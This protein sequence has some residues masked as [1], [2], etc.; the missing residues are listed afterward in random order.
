VQY[1]CTGGGG[2]NLEVTY[3]IFNQDTMLGNTTITWWNQTSTQYQKVTYESRPWNSSKYLTHTGFSENY[4]HWAPEDTGKYYYHLPSAELYNDAG[5][6]LGFEYA[7]ECY[8]YIQVE[9]NA[10]LCTISVHY[11]NGVLL[12]GP[13]DNHPQQW[14]FQK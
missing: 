13:E 7:E 6:Q 5:Q 11:P 2:A 8:H 10:T 12:S 14:S 4:T 3:G 9:I 1:F